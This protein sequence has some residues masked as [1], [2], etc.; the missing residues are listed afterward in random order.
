MKIKIHSIHFNA[1]QK[2]LAFIEDKVDRL[3]TYYEHIIDGEVY[4]KLEP[5]ALE[6]KIVEI[7]VNAPGK[8]LFAKDQKKT[9][10]EATSSAFDAL[11]K[12]VQKHKEKVRGL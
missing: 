5:D 6:N 8:T 3:L 11:K 1:D 12:Q 7:K 10:E 9:F 2:L 4:L